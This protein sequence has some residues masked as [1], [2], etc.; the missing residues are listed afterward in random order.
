MI[1]NVDKK[2]SGLLLLLS[3]VSLLGVGTI[4]LTGL[5]KNNP[6]NSTKKD[7]NNAAVLGE[8]TADINRI[9]SDTLQSTKDT[10]SQKTAEVQKTI[11]NNIEKEVSNLAESQIETLKL[12]ICRDWGLVK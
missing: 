12:Q 5:L 4:F 1:R 7:S 8:K 9:V 3:I 2:K 10:V 11:V 6:K